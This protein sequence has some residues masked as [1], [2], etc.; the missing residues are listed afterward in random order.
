MERAAMRLTALVGYRGGSVLLCV[1]GKVVGIPVIPMKLFMEGWALV[2][3]G[4]GTVEYL[5]SNWANSF[6]LETFAVGTFHERQTNI[7]NYSLVLPV[8]LQFSFVLADGRIQ[9]LITTP[10]ASWS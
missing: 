3:T 9:V 10:F 1:R 6:R 4:A 8:L 5:Y 7:R 2:M